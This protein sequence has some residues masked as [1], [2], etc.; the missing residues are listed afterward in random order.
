M[1]RKKRKDKTFG[2]A[3]VS[4][5]DVYGSYTG[6]DLDNPYAEPTQD[7]DDL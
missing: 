2:S 1:K 6:T 4:T 3:F 7:V 5:S